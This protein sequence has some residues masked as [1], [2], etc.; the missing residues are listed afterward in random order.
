MPTNLFVPFKM[1]AAEND[2]M[3]T[4]IKNLQTFIQQSSAHWGNRSLDSFLKEAKAAAKHKKSS[5]ADKVLWKLIVCLPY[6]LTAVILILNDHL[7]TVGVLTLTSSFRGAHSAN[8]TA[9][10]SPDDFA[11]NLYSPLCQVNKLNHALIEPAKAVFWP[12]I[13]TIMILILLIIIG[14]MIAFIVYRAMH[15]NIQVVHFYGKVRLPTTVR[16]NG[17]RWAIV[18]NTI[19]HKRTLLS[20]RIEVVQI[21]F[22]TA[23]NP[24]AFVHSPTTNLVWNVTSYDI[25][26]LGKVEVE[27]ENSNGEPQQCDIQIECD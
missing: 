26:L 7:F 23:L 20:K 18:S 8:V 14:L 11:C 2:Q 13:R 15:K 9:A 19:L 24:A 1:D 21:E 25:A 6:L 27:L 17:W 10:I 5:L 4:D 22:E 3:R 16:K 12:I